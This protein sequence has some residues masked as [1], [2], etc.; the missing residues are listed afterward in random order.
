M[1]DLFEYAALNA[2]ITFGQRGVPSPNRRAARRRDHRVYAA[3]YSVLAREGERTVVGELRTLT[4]SP[5]RGRLL[6]V[7][8]GPA[9]DLEHL[10][11]SIES[12]VALEP[13]VAM[14][15]RGR[16]R[17]RVLQERMPVLVL[18]GVA[19]QLPLRDDSV[20]AVLCAFVLCS[21]DDVQRCLHEFRRVLRPDGQLLLL[22][23]VGA[24]P[25]TRTRR[26]QELLD[27]MWPHIA[28]GCHLTRDLTA[29]LVA[30]GFDA[31]DVRDLRL[32]AIPI[33]AASVTGTARPRG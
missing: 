3:L 1:A 5:A 33:C 14:L 15:N 32:R 21:V 10:P 31:E 29:E 8:L 2:A 20:D 19:E 26:V 30:A 25:G 4:L 17:V 18:Q 23:H 22:E 9:Y 7:G 13:S 24:T 6:V 27:P 16:Q 12:V 11:P 28:A